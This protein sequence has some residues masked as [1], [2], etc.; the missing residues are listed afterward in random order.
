MGNRVKLSGL[1][2]IMLVV[3]LVFSGC[4][5]VGSNTIKIGS[6]HPLT[7]SMAYEGQAMVNAQRIAIDKINAEGGING[8]MLEL[9]A[10]DSMG[11][12][13]GAANA[14][15]KLTNSGVV[16]LTGTYTSSSAQVVS[17]TAEK[18]GIPLVVTVASSDNLLSNGYKYTFRIQPSVSVFS[19]NFLEYLDFFRTDDMKTI[20]FIYENSNYGT[21]IAEYIKNHIDETGLEI[22]GMLAYPATTSTLSAE[23]TKLV[24]LNPDLLVPIGYYS[25]QSLMMK[26]ILERDIHFNK[27]VGCANGAFSD[28]KFLKTF[29]DQVDGILD[30]NYRY[31]PNSP[32]AQY[33]MKTY[34][35][36]YGEDI[37]VH[38]IY[39]YQS[40]MVIADALKRCE[41]PDDTAMLR[42]AIA[43]SVI[44]EHVLPQA[45]I[46]FDEKGENVNSAGVLVEIRDGKHV[47]VFPEEYSDADNKEAE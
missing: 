14:A 1:V 18:T 41:N 47:I 3:A 8:R 15:M 25:D 10:R 11:T 21:G 38:A 31:N 42:D 12:S 32:E 36:T 28:A 30:I 34:R 43:S 16:A 9:V 23:V 35:E 44:E 19:R 45:E 33:M 46:R 6:V 7:G 24:S 37:P 26:E 4:G 20:A 40:I 22:V 5:S 13:S 39:G 17:R 29:G 27:I 2:L